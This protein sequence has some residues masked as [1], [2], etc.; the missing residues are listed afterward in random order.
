M[1][2]IPVSGTSVGRIIRRICSIVCR[3]GDKPLTRKQH[4]EILFEIQINHTSMTTEDFFV[5]DS[6]N[7]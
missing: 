6:R 2:N 3:S 4:P 7:R 1:E 5:N